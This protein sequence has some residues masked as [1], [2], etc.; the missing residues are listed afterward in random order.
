LDDIK[1][2]RERRKQSFDDNTDI[3]RV[4]DNTNLKY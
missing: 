4:L 3:T 1:Y 2:N